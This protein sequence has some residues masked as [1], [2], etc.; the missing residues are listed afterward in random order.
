MARLLIGGISGVILDCADEG[1][2][3][4]RVAVVSFSAAAKDI[5]SARAKK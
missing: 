5:A 1:P 3:R 2:Q 4:E